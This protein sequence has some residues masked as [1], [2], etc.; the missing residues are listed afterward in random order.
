MSSFPS[1]SFRAQDAKKGDLTKQD[2]CSYSEDA[3]L[4]TAIGKAYVFPLSPPRF[5]PTG[6]QAG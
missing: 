1:N 4:Y 6:F 2:V 5:C 3:T